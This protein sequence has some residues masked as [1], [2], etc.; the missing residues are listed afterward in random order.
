MSRR[1]A[2]PRRKLAPGIACVIV[3]IVY[4][5]PIVLLILSSFKPLSQV[6]NSSPRSFWPLNL[7]AYRSTIGSV[8]TPL[9]NSIIIAVSA[10][11]L[12]TALA[13]AAAYG[14]VRMGTGRSRKV[15]LIV[16]GALILFQMIPQATAVTPVYALL[17]KFHLIDSLLGLVIVDS[18]LLVPFAV[19]VL[20]PHVMNVPF[21]LEESARMDGAATLTVFRRVVLPLMRNGIVVTWLLLF[22]VF[23]GEFIYAV[24]FLNSPNLFPLSVIILD[25]V[26]NLQTAWNRLLALAVIAVAPI[27]VILAFTQRQLRE[28]LNAGAFK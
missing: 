17:V 13:S 8:L 20:R 21:E 10:S 9:K 25:Q 1:S 26:G 4:A 5:A 23:W 16:L 28:G 19:L 12:T 24:T 18:G 6:F 14:L 7:S 22:I 3:C 2:V 11:T 15:A 27:L